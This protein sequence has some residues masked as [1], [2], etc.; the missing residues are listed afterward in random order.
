M[1]DFNNLDWNVEESEF[2]KEI[3]VP[4]AI[5]GFFNVK[6]DRSC[7]KVVVNVSTDLMSEFG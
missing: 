4:Y 7:L 3:S 1:D 5:E 6:E 2:V